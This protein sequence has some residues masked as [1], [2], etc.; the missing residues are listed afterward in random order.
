MAWYFL[1]FISLFAAFGLDK[2]FSFSYSKI[3]KIT[4]FII[5]LILTLPSAYDNFRVYFGHLDSS[6]L[7]LTSPYFKAMQF[8]KSHGNYNKTVIE[9]PDKNID[10]T[11][12]DVLRW[13][14]S[15]TPAISAFANKRSYLSN[16]YIDF[17]GIDIVPRI[18]LIRKIILLNN[19]PLSD[20]SEYINLQKEVKQ[21]L[22]DNKIVFIY[23]PYPLL[24]FEK[25]N[26][27]SKV[28]ENRAA[29]IY[30]VEYKNY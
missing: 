28:Y 27:V 11:K 14:G 13:Y 17:T 21:G 7:T 10:A 4:L 19:L 3:L 15:L 23:S 2:L 12:K 1:F 6:K 16:E 26:L 18:N 8:L 30:R 29:S 22:G 20:S 25:M 5:I 9:I 24:S